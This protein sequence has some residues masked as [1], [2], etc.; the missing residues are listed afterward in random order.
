MTHLIFSEEMMRP[1]GSAGVAI[2][3]EN[4]SSTLIFLQKQIAFFSEEIMRCFIYS[5]TKKN[6]HFFFKEMLRQLI[7][8]SIEAKINPRTNFWAGTLVLSPGL[9]AKG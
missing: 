9:I 3:S 7:F 5:L 6:I 8:L 4:R 1:T 2:P